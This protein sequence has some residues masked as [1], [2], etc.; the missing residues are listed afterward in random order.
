[1]IE[2]AI[3]SSETTPTLEQLG[4][5][6]ITWNL[7]PGTPPV[8]IEWAKFTFDATKDYY[9]EL[10][11]D[12]KWKSDDGEYP[13]L[14]GLQRLAHTYR[15]G[16]KAYLADIISTPHRENP[17][18]AV[19]VQVNFNDGTTFS[20]VA[21]ATPA[22]HAKPFS[23][24]LVAVAESKAASRAFRQAFNISKATR[25]EIGQPAVEDDSDESIEDFQL[26]GIRKLAERKNII[27]K[28]SLKLIKSKKAAW[29]DLTK[30]EARQLMKALNK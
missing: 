23:L 13:L 7:I 4:T 2:Q 6:N 9:A 18:A 8:T 25:E 30:E 10:S 17:I 1:M 29:V 11:S 22:A 12:E 19:R 3:K 27:E 21:D 14:R 16:I 28:D 5:S 15:G 24:H 26:A 20:G